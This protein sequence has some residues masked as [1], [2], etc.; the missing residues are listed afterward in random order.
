MI[1]KQIACPHCRGTGAD[2]P[3]DVVKCRDC[4]GKGR[5]TRRV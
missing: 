1:Q 4:E 2:N 3:K 5:I